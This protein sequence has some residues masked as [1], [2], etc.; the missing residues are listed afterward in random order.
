MAQYKQDI[1]N[2]KW[3]Y[4]TTSEYIK[5]QQDIS[6]NKWSYYRMKIIDL[7]WNQ[8]PYSKKLNCY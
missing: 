5:Q 7:E 8:N 6:H 2:N 1:S 3:M 4:Q